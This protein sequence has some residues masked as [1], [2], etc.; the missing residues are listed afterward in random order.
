MRG[1]CIGRRQVLMIYFLRV[2]DGFCHW[3]HTA[4]SSSVIWVCAVCMA[5]N[6][7]WCCRVFSVPSDWPQHLNNAPMFGKPTKCF[8]M[9]R[10]LTVFSS[11]SSPL[12]RYNL[13]FVALVSTILLDPIV[14][15]YQF[16]F[17]ISL[18]IPPEPDKWRFPFGSTMSTFVLEFGWIAWGCI[19]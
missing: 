17:L 14:I 9:K 11:L 3:E 16:L 4:V 13:S 6:W 15:C 1:R 7:I 8:R 2:S 12:G 10:F 5:A 18:S 19:E